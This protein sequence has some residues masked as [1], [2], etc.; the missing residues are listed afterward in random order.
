VIISVSDNHTSNREVPLRFT[1]SLAPNVGLKVMNTAV[2]R[3][4]ERLIIF[5]DY[6]FWAAR[7]EK[8]DLLGM[9]VADENTVV[10]DDI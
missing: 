4:K 5:C 10:R 7:A 2:S 1:S 6:E 8:G 3:A 9:I